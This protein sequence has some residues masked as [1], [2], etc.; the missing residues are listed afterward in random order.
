MA[1]LL[2]FERIQQRR[3]KT[4]VAAHKLVIIL[5]AVHPGQVKYKINLLAVFVQLLY[6]G[7]QIVL[8]YLIYM[9]TRTSSVLNY[10]LYFLSRSPR[11]APGAGY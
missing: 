9:D 2:Y 11:H 5:R 1:V 7:I 10:L 8:K 4:K 3:C 6:C